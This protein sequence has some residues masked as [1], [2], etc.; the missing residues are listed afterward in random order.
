[1]ANWAELGRSRI[2][3]AVL[4]DSTN[5]WNLLPGWPLTH[6]SGPFPELGAT[7]AATSNERMDKAHPLEIQRGFAQKKAKKQQKK[8]QETKGFW[9][10]PS[11]LAIHYGFMKS[12]PWK[13][14]QEFGCSSR[15][16]TT[17][18][19][20]LSRGNR[21]ELCTWHR[22]TSCQ[23]DGSTQVFTKL[24]LI[25]AMHQ[26]SATNDVTVIQTFPREYY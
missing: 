13:D 3:S 23:R 12:T 21:S 14:S 7:E 24:R 8:G 11:S 19:F 18:I 25:F 16:C 2:L 1:M 17:W 4:M 10:Y 20:L 22:P 26:K 9:F 5:P 6:L 15:P